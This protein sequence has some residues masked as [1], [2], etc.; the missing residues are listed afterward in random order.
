MRTLLSIWHILLL[1]TYIYQN[2]FVKRHQEPKNYEILNVTQ[3]IIYK[4]KDYAPWTSIWG[5]AFDID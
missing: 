4:L 3:K 2:H 5:C 1:H